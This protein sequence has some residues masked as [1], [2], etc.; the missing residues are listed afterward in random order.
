MRLRCWSS[1]HILIFFRVSS[2]GN[3]S[4]IT[5]RAKYYKIS[6]LITDHQNVLRPFGYPTSTPLWAKNHKNVKNL[7]DFSH[8]AFA[9]KFNPGNI[10]IA[11]NDVRIIFWST[12]G[13]RLAL[14]CVPSQGSHDSVRLDK[15]RLKVFGTLRVTKDIVQSLVLYWW[16]LRNLA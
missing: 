10:L 9:N 14:F 4:F 15:E 2:P 13:S 7:V 11:S 16:S 12:A 3:A 8:A 5:F 6:I 1:C